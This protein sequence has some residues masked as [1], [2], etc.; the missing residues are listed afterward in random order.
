MFLDWK[1]Q[2]CEND[3]TTQS[4][5]QIQC[6]PYQI[7]NV[8]FYRSRTKYLKICME[9]QK[10]PNSQSNLEGKKW[11]WRNQAPG[12]QTILQATVIKTVWYWHKNRNIDQWN[13]TESPEINPRTYGHLIFD[14]GGKTTQWRKDSPFNKW[15]W[16]N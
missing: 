6:N 5:L 4:N 10:T 12:L 8:I 9:T 15:C 13:R 14:K 1:N 16:E 3:Y 2:Y 7:T 11:S